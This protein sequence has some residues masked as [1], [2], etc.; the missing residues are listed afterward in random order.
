MPFLILISFI[1][2]CSFGLI[3]NYLGNLDPAFVSA[4]RLFL[5]ALIFI[6]L[7][8]P[9]RVSKAVRLKLTFVGIVQY[10]LMYIL[11]M[12]SFRYLAA[13]EVALFTIFTPVFVTSFHDFLEKR[14]HPVFFFCAVLTVVGSGIVLWRQAPRETLW[15][16][17]FLVQGSNACFALG[18]VLYKKIMVGIPKVKDHEIFGFLF[19]GGFGISAAAV[20]I[21]AGPIVPGVTPVQ[22]AV[23]LYLGLVGSGVCFFLW[24]Y[25]ARKVDAG[26]LAILNNL[27]IPLAV[28]CSV[29]FFHEEILWGRFL[30]GVGIFLAGLALNRL[31]SKND[32]AL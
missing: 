6:P 29:I 27:K 30:A 15:L 20:L 19:A 11:Y 32:P 16:G 13:Y 28:L 7:L 23:L 24:N 1:W 18:Q 14:F 4:A 31:F 9:A 21:F 22:A 10:G 3:K 12:M 8:K 17:F 2:A 26:A 25:G 5:A